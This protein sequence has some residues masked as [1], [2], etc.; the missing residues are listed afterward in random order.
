MIKLPSLDRVTINGRNA[1]Y[2]IDDLI[3]LIKSLKDGRLIKEGVDED[4][5]DKVKKQIYDQDNEKLPSKEWKELAPETPRKKIEI[6]NYYD[7]PLRMG[8][9]KKW[10]M[11]GDVEDSIVSLPSPTLAMIKVGILE[12]KINPHQ[13]RVNR[14]TG[15]TVDVKIKDYAKSLE[16]ERPLFSKFWQYYENWM[17]NYMAELMNNLVKKDVSASAVDVFY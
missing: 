15:R 4:L 13:F 16:R 1:G 8:S 3:N 6:S 12:D 14:R 2:F 9:T 11:F 5:V 10:S 17:K 7:I